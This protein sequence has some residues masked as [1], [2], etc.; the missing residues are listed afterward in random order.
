MRL[1]AFGPA[2]RN[3]L[4]TIRDGHPDT[5]LLVVSPILCPAQGARPDRRRRTSRTSRREA[6][7]RPARRP[8]RGRERQARWV[9]RAELARI[10]AERAVDDPAWATSTGASSTAGGPPP[11]CRCPT[12]CTPRRRDAPADGRQFARLAFEAVGGL[13]ARTSSGV[14]TVDRRLRHDHPMLLDCSATIDAVRPCT[15]RTRAC[16]WVPTTTSSASSPRARG[17]GRPGPGSARRS[18]RR[19]GTPRP[20]PGAVSE[21]SS[22]ST[23]YPASAGPTSP[24]GR[25]RRRCSATRSGWRRRRPGGRRTPAPGSTCRARRRRRAHTASRPGGS[26]GRRMTTGQAGWRDGACATDP[27]SRL[28]TEPRPPGPDDQHRGLG[29]SSSNASRR[30]SS[31]TTPRTRTSGPARRPGR[32][33]LSKAS[34]SCR[35][36]PSPAAGLQRRP[37]PSR[38]APPYDAGGAPAIKVP[39]LQ[40]RLLGRPGDRT[41]G[42]LG[43][44]DADDDGVAGTSV[45]SPTYVQREPASGTTATGHS[46]VL[47]DRVRHRPVQDGAGGRAMVGTDDDQVHPP[48][49]PGRGRRRDCRA[50]SRVA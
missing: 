20:C 14:A 45:M 15:S 46:R 27:S 12:T 5:P 50:M 37:G 23:S 2:V 31:A 19:R 49:L 4:D 21:S 9:I 44:V 17:C 41:V 34:A 16:S 26:A 3:F 39:V 25:G 38:A 6:A 8:D 30:S 1:R 40:A 33:P 36:P 13:G 32:P 10:V 28:A 47:D 48:G 42:R 35:M 24:T 29:A 7:V 18:R 22:R 11:S 43:A